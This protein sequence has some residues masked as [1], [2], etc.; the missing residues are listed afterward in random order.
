MNVR[1]I[2]KAIYGAHRLAD[3]GTWPPDNSV[4][5]FIPSTKNFEEDNDLLLRV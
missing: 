1:F 4:F 5:D 3:F 2:V